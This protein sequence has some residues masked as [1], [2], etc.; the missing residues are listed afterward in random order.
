MAIPR[1]ETWHWTKRVCKNQQKAQADKWTPQY[2]RLKNAEGDLSKSFKMQPQVLNF[3]FSCGKQYKATWVA[4]C[5]VHGIWNYTGRLRN[6][7]AGHYC[8]DSDM[9]GAGFRGT[10]WCAGRMGWGQCECPVCSVTR[11]TLTASWRPPC[12]LWLQVIRRWSWIN[13]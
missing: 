5:Y 4:N 3:C 12:S 13:G 2:M 8:R 10:L 11:V 7:P 1:L 6:R 9:R